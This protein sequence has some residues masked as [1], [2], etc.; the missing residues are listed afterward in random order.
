MHTNRKRKKPT[1]KER[2]AEKKRLNLVARLRGGAKKEMD[3]PDCPGVAESL[4]DYEE[5]GEET[6]VDV[7]VATLS[8][9]IEAQVV[10]MD[11]FDDGGEVEDDPPDNWT[12]YEELDAT[13]GDGDEYNA[14]DVLG[15]A[16]AILNE[17][18]Q[19]SNQT[20]TNPGLV[21]VPNEMIAG[22]RL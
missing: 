22:I 16:E 1:R 8:R 7:D 2:L 10:A 15:D 12:S 21:S 6:T 18:S 9:N 4:S 19:S 14:A 3:A 13:N 11:E 5:S 20:W 17:D